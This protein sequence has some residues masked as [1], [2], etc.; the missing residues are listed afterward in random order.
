MN[1]SRN[2]NDRE[3]EKML[4]WKV[5]FLNMDIDVLED[6]NTRLQY[7]ID[8]YKKENNELREKLSAIGGVGDDM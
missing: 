6:E 1:E 5:T 8:K 2:F 4:V 7:E 3:F